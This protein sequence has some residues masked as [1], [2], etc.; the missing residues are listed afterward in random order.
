MSRNWRMYGSTPF[1]PMSS[2][3]PAAIHVKPRRLS[4]VLTT[5]ALLF[6]EGEA[7]EKDVLKYL[8]QGQIRLELCRDLL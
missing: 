6:D 1:P 7:R 4:R 8:T 5:A 3:G 2:A